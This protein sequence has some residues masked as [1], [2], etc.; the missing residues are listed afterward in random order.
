[1]E[2]GVSYYIVPAASL[3][4]RRKLP[5]GCYAAMVA[6]LRAE[7]PWIP[8]RLRAPTLSLQAQLIAR[9]RRFANQAAKGGI[10]LMFD[11][12]NVSGGA[13]GATASEIEQS[14]MISSFGPLSGVVPDGVATV[15]VRYPASNGLAARTA[16]SDVVGNLFVTAIRSSNRGNLWSAMIWRSAQGKI[17][18]TVPASRGHHF[19]DSR[20]CSAPTRN[21]C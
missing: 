17:V 8:V 11:S 3:S 12:A 10:C 1:M 19:P 5:A 6:A 9:Q 4:P 16:T 7:L 13:C 14:G 2:D 15:T 20:F 21:A 18:K